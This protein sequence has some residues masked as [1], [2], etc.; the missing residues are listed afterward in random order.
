MTKALLC[1]RCDTRIDVN[2]NGQPLVVKNTTG[3]KPSEVHVCLDCH[4][5]IRDELY[6][7]L[8]D[9]GTTYEHP[10]VFEF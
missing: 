8:L 2:Y 3:T 6:E 10:D 9:D 5:E 1:D 4:T 7:L